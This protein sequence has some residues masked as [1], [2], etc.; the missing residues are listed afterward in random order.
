MQSLS[1]RWKITLLSGVCLIITCAAVIG[2]FI[3]NSVASQAVSQQQSR[4]SMIDK[5]RELLES[6]AQGNA[7]TVESFIEEAQFRA[8]MLAENALFIKHNAEENFVSSE[9]L[10][11]SLNEMLGRTVERFANIKGAYIAFDANALDGEDSYYHNAAYVGSNETGR[12]APYWQRGA[13]GIV[14]AS[15]LPESA[16]ANASLAERYQCAKTSGSACLS[17]PQLGVDGTLVSVISVPLTVDKNLGV[18][19]IEIELSSLQG[20]VQQSDQSLFDGTGMVTVLTSSGSVLFDSENSYSPLTSFVSNHFSN[21]E[22]SQQLNQPVSSFWSQDGEWLLSVAPVTVANQTWG[23]LLEVPQQQVIADALA[24]DN[25]M[26]EQLS[27]SITKNLLFA[28]IMIVLALA[29]T[30]FL[31][32]TL[33]KSIQQ[34]VTR[35]EDIASGDG[36][37]T[38][39]I[40]VK[41]K[42]E[43]GQL[44]SGFNQFLQKLQP[45]IAQVVSGSIDVAQTAQQA[46]SSASQSRQNSESQFREVDMVATAAEELTQTASMVFDNAEVAVKAA[47]QANQS[48]SQGQAVVQASTSSMSELLV[49]ME[50]AV[51]VVEELARNNANITEILSVI[52]GISEKTNLLALNAAIEAARAGEQ[53]RGFAVV[54]DEVRQLASR[55]NESVAEIQEVIAK[56]QQGTDNVVKSI[57]SGNNLAKEA[58]A[59]VSNAVDELNHTFT[60]IASI[61]DMNAQIVRAAQEQ[62]Q[63]ASEVNVSVANI[64]DLSAQLLEQAELSE[65]VGES[66]ASASKQQQTLV[67]QFKV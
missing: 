61:S 31:A 26:T 50:S 44:A 29:V 13:D 43:I 22:L 48:A 42:D 60:S 19:G 20:I 28:S 39:R 11:T 34:V 21:Q 18:L 5:S 24:L 56:V 10:R 8:E 58:S 3:Q 36:D 12:F 66:I 32:S 35:L 41:S 51:P 4:Q 2:F 17:T 1:I 47:E 25:A 54:A 15:V 7:V 55:T 46:Q 52:E 9:D 64:R 45:I 63:V 16:L 65:T 23:V 67:A 37:L 6:N 14:S 53:G 62:Q 30:S 57:A 38:Q 40:E 49:E 59:Q 27:Q 33:V